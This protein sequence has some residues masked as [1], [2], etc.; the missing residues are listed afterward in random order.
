MRGQTLYRATVV[1]VLGGTMAGLSQLLAGM[2]PARPRTQLDATPGSTTTTAPSG[3]TTAPAPSTTT[4][5]PLP[6][7][8]GP[9]RLDERSKFDGRGVGPIEAGMTVAEAEQAAGRRFTV[10][11]AD[12]GAACWFA[13]VDGLPGLRMI[14]RG[15]A[16]DGREGRISRI[17]ASDITWTTVSGAR[18]GAS[19]SEVQRLYGSRAKRSPDGRRLTVTVKDGG[20]SFAVVFL[21]SERATVTALWSGEAAAM[22]QPEGCG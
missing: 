20:R 5:V 6:P 21:L 9:V 18:V 12:P 11:R 15:P 14:V 10:D 2:E 13:T 3:T 1:I 7:I 17:E 16:V 19:E 8:A 22:T 4:T